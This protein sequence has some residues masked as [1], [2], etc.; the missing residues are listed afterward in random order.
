MHIT[1]CEPDRSDRNVV[2]GNTISDTTA[3]SI[4]I[5]EGT[6]GGTVVGQ[7]LRRRRA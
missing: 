4:D 7:H 1:D 3:E 2:A 6:T 5:K